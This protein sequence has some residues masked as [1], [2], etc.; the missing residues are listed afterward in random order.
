M[1][2]RKISVPILDQIGKYSVI[3]ITGPRQS[4]KTTLI[5][6]HF[7]ELPYL[8]LWRTLT[9]GNSYRPIRKLCFVSM[10]NC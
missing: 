4:G 1:I 5:R 6:E 8:S 10:A 7:P 9:P 2:T 3:M